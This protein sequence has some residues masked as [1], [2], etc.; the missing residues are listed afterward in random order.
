MHKC[1]IRR[2]FYRL[3]YNVKNLF[4]WFTLFFAIMGIIDLGWHYGI[5]IDHR[6]PFAILHELMKSFMVLWIILALI[7]L[8]FPA[9]LNLYFRYI[10]WWI[11]CR[12]GIILKWIFSGWRRALLLLAGIASML[13]VR[14]IIIS[15]KSANQEGQTNL[16]AAYFWI[17]I[18][19]KWTELLLPDFWMKVFAISALLFVVYWA[20][21]SRKRIVLLQFSNQTGDDKLNASAEGISTILMN[22]ITRLV[23]L[24]TMVDDTDPYAPSS[25]G[26]NDESKDS[27]KSI[28][29]NISVSGVG[30][31]LKSVVTSDSKVKLGFLEVPIGAI[32]GILGTTVEGPK[33]SGSLQKEGKCLVLLAKM[34]GGGIK[35]DWRISSSDL[36]GE[37]IL[38]VDHVARLTRQLANRIFTDLEKEHLGTPR[39]KAVCHYT[40]GLRAYR[41]TLRTDR[42]KD[43]QLRRAEREFLLA[44]GEDMKFL[45]CYYNLGIVYQALKQPE[46]AFSVLNKSV[47]PHLSRSY[48][49]KVY[50]A[51]AVNHSWIQKNR[52]KYADYRLTIQL[53]DKAV[54]LNPDDARA[55]DK[56]GMVKRE[57]NKKEKEQELAEKQE[58]GAALEAKRDANQAWLS[59]II[60]ALQLTLDAKREKDFWKYEIIP[61]REIATALAWRRIC[62]C[63]FYGLEDK[64]AK[65]IA[66]TC[67]R[68]LAVAHAQADTKSG[69]P[70]FHQSI[71]LSPHD[72]DLYFEL[73]KTENFIHKWKEAAAVF[74]D[75][76]R[77]EQKPEYWSGLALAYSGQ[78]KSSME[79]R[80]F[81]AKI[82]PP[83][84]RPYIYRM[85]KDLKQS[86]LY[87][88]SH[89]LD[90]AYELGGETLRELNDSL[91]KI[92]TCIL[93]QEKRLSNEKDEDYRKRLDALNGDIMSSLEDS[94][95]QIS[96][97]LKQLYEKKNEMHKANQLSEKMLEIKGLFP[98]LA[99]SMDFFDKFDR[100]KDQNGKDESDE[101]YKERLKQLRNENLNLDFACALISQ[102]LLS[103][104]GDNEAELRGAISKL[105]SVHPL[106]IAR[107][108]FH[109]KLAHALLNPTEP[110]LGQSLYHAQRSVTLDPVDSINRRYISEVY[111][112]YGSYEE[113]GGQLE[114][115]FSLDP[116]DANFL[117]NSAFLQS[118]FNPGTKKLEDS[119]KALAKYIENL[120]SSMVLSQSKS[121]GNEESAEEEMLY[122]SWIHYSLAGA[123]NKLDDYEKAIHNYII[124][125]NLMPRSKRS[126]FIA[127]FDLGAAYWDN[128]S[129]AEC[130][131][132]YRKL[133]EELEEIIKNKNVF[134]WDEIPKKDNNRFKEYLVQRLG[135]DWATA[136]NIIEIEK[137]KTIQI[138][139]NTNCLFLRLNQEKSGVTLIIDD[140]RIDKFKAAD[141]DGD[142]NIYQKPI[143]EIASV[144]PAGSEFGYADVTLGYL[145]G[146]ACLNLAFC[147]SER[148]ANLTNALILAEKANSYIKHLQNGERKRQLEA[149]YADHRG[150]ILYKQAK[151][152]D[153][154]QDINNAIDCLKRAVCMKVSPDYY[155][156]LALALEHKLDTEGENSHKNDTGKNEM[157]RNLV[158]ALAC[159]DHTIDLDIQK[160]FTEQAT[161]LKKRL[162]DLKNNSLNKL[163]ATE[164]KEC[165]DQL[166]GYV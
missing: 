87:A 45:Y 63:A 134:S 149:D 139:T 30:E 80:N 3:S 21:Q 157:K 122:R 154:L 144:E 156:H 29:P 152:G 46:S 84:V 151:L 48:L 123:Y 24:C 147:F 95:T 150:W 36:S 111:G 127:E 16:S 57:K 83:I 11:S 129:Y 91:F 102:R 106:E 88:C 73:A 77:I 104:E 166:K 142:L 113:A 2:E 155:L 5:V 9:W 125:K 158:L 67:V 138:A 42:N 119:K 76:L 22:E 143:E 135:I 86:A 85:K 145:I 27:S 61:V 25:Q 26:T 72:A 99:K 56:I 1:E 62:R 141:Y 23:N 55:W 4:W 38:T 31:N 132:L 126:H 68:N 79:W 140:G 50:Y 15:N 162:L 146:F 40:E 52:A 107:Q 75:A 159:C 78:Y 121:L 32:M 18:D 90:Y 101:A 130:E 136:G 94:F 108:G 100:M 118:G 65:K 117:L 160:K 43:S 164:E 41:E 39:W 7:W 89:A 33:L 54:S 6:I 133:I 51:L 59:N 44:L 82:L 8:A 64:A 60:A 14:T 163:N 47:D 13:F 97:R 103:L 69:K 120:T 153:G 66:I 35:G 148:D 58:F 10:A 112:R 116:K 20:Y 105:E 124:A 109:G 12:C 71:Y 53:C 70:F 17:G 28:D 110:K 81:F 128:R 98:K 165:A 161:D 74:E 34:S 49:S 96:P 114:I 92:S 37:D 137:S 131:E 115:G 19:N 93:D